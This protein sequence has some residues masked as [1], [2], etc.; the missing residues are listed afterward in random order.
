[1][2]SVSARETVEGNAFA[3]RIYRIDCQDQN[4]QRINLLRPFYEDRIYE[5]SGVEILLAIP[6]IVVSFAYVLTPCAGL[7]HRSVLFQT[8]AQTVDTVASGDGQITVLV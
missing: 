6:L 3:G 5:Y 1:M 4:M 8:Y 2:T 7:G